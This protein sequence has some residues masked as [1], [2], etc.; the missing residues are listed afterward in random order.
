MINKISYA[1]FKGGSGSWDLPARAM[2]TGR[3]CGGKTRI[4]EAV[5]LA[6]IGSEFPGASGLLG[7]ASDSH[8]ISV[9][10]YGELGHRRYTVF[11]KWTSPRKGDVEIKGDTDAYHEDRQQMEALAEWGTA[12]G[13]R[14]QQI[15]AGTAIGRRLCAPLERLLRPGDDG[16]ER[17][18]E[19]ELA[20]LG[21]QRRDLA[22]SIRHYT[23]HLRVIAAEPAPSAERVPME[24]MAEAVRKCAD[25]EEETIKARAALDQASR[26]M[27]KIDF[28]RPAAPECSQR[29]NDLKDRLEAMQMRMPAALDAVMEAINANRGA[30]SCPCCG[31]REW[32]PCDWS[33]PSQEMRKI[34]QE[35]REIKADIATTPE[36]AAN[37]RSAHTDASKVYLEALQVHKQAVEERDALRARHVGAAKY[38]QQCQQK[39][40]AEKGLS[41]A[42]AEADK[43]AEKEKELK[44]ALKDCMEALWSEIATRAK[45]TIDLFAKDKLVAYKNGELGLVY[46]GAFTP[47]SACCGS[48]RLAIDLAVRCA[49]SPGI[50]VLDEAARLAPEALEAVISAL[51]PTIGQFICIM[52]TDGPLTITPIHGLEVA[53]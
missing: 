19:A 41:E 10:V 23:G 22:A 42:E 24:I 32:E 8:P 11:R 49:L 1:N 40:D 20:K 33:S 16:V 17:R 15:L 48:E 52:P 25:M 46:K 26:E 38:A 29:A 31:A 27:G 44:T 13:P 5:Y 3:N 37:L 45:G 7:G 2:I 39:I 30:E 36:E 35:L 50:V 28:S 12:T 9:C 21:E 51:P 47:Q 18:A 14:R 4:I 43:V 53:Q 34:L 6:M